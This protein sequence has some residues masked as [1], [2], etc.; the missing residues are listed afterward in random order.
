MVWGAVGAGVAV[1]GAV[2]GGRA[3]KRAAA[4]EARFKR[5]QAA[6]TRDQTA[7]AVVRQDKIARKTLGAMRA[8]YGAAGV[9]VDGSPLD[10]LAESAAAA[11]LDKLTIQYQ[12]ELTA[13]GYQTDAR[14]TES[15]G[16][17]ADT[18]GGFSAAGALMSWVA[19]EWDS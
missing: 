11:E 9:T 3:K 1:V 10:V 17:A 19:D 12:G 5:W 14:L 7:A 18:A 2:S 4:K 15:A 6:Y 16:R 13:K 8:A